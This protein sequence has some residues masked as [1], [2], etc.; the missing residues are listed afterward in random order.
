M[1]KPSRTEYT[2]TD[3]ERN[4]P[5]LDSGSSPGGFITLA[6]AG[7]LW[8][9]AAFTPPRVAH[10]C[11]TSISSGSGVGW[12]LSLRTQAVARRAWHWWDYTVR[13][14]FES[15]MQTFTACRWKQTLWSVFELH[16]HGTLHQNFCYCFK[17]P[18]R[19]F[20][21]VYTKRLKLYLFFPSLF[22]LIPSHSKC[23]VDLR[24]KSAQHSML[25]QE[26]N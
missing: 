5:Q 6:T 14:H 24:R 26:R 8:T 12:G 19:S 17:L 9:F 21:E 15:F 22:F 23:C 13:F 2:R 18:P 4:I 16:E 20:T 7:R 11:T 10:F 25:D 3:E 1:M